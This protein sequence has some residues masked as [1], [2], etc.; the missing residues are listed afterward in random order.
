MQN[1]LITIKIK[2]QKQPDKKWDSVSHFINSTE[3]RSIYRQVKKLQQKFEI[4][5]IRTRRINESRCYFGRRIGLRNMFR[6][7]DCTS[8]IVTMIYPSQLYDFMY[9]NYYKPHVEKG[10]WKIEFLND[11]VVNDEVV[12][13]KK[14]Y[15]S[16]IGDKVVLKELIGGKK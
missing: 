16:L 8:I 9:E 14:H 15:K 1:K 13:D 4:K 12:T 5:F 3:D 10:L 11:T 7:D 2:S 6:A